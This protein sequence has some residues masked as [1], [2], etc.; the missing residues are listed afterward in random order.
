MRLTRGILAAIAL[1]AV[2]DIARAVTVDDPLHGII[3]SGVGTGCSNAA[4]NGSFTPLSQTN[5]WSFAISPGPATGDLTLVFLVPTNTINVALFNLPGI[6]DNNL[7]T[8]GAT[9]FD[10]VNLFTAASPG[11]STYL[12]LAGAFSPTNNFANSSAGEAT[13]NPGFLGAFLAFTLTL[14]DV[15]LGDVASTTTAHD[16]SF[17]SNLPAGTV[18]LGLFIEEFDKHGNP[19]TNN[20]AIGTAAS[21][22]LVITPFAAE[23]PLP[24]AVWLFGGGLGVLGLLARRRKRTRGAWDDL[25]RVDFLPK[26]V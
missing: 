7:P 9:V 2:T 22:D 4:D 10:R 13:L 5:N 21:A 11:V 6:T 25:P 15:T 26:V 14:N 8:I 3:C 19:C 1:L 20:C 16:F 24:A 17:G 23:T 18:I 12:G